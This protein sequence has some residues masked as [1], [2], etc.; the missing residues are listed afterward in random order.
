MISGGGGASILINVK[1]VR[2]LFR[3]CSDSIN[4]FFYANCEFSMNFHIFFCIM[5]FSVTKKQK[6][7]EE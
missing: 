4:V 7:K 1:V 2:P 6:I 5:T 3:A